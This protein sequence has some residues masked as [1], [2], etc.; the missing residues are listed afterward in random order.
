VSQAARVSRNAHRWSPC[1]RRIFFGQRGELRQAYREG[2]EDQPSA[3]GLALNATVLRN[4]LYS[5]HAVGQLA[6]DGLSV[7]DELARLSPLQFEHINF[8]GRYTFPQLDG[9]LRPLRDPH[10]PD[11]E[12]SLAA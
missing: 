5:D 3:P 11:D 10:P 9:A 1:A 2:M 8:H 7:T 12:D 6:A 4:T